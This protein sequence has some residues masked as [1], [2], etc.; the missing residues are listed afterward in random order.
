[1]ND[2]LCAEKQ[3][4]LPIDRYFT[5]VW[6]FMFGL[7]ACD[8]READIAGDAI[9]FIN[10]GL[11]ADSF[12]LDR[13]VIAPRRTPNRTFRP[14]ALWLWTLISSSLICRLC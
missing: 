13:F 2:L 7:L 5:N 4:P 14:K 3:M 8:L 11:A 9:E 10:T 1:M 6:P 12:A